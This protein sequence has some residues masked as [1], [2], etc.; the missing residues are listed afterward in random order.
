MKKRG[1]WLEA[2][3][4]FL[5][6][7]GS[8]K[9]IAQNSGDF[10]HGVQ[11]RIK[12][13][14]QAFEQE[15]YIIAFDRYYRALDKEKD[16]ILQ[17]EIWYRLG[18][19]QQKLNHA[20]EAYDY[21]IRVWKN[22]RRDGKF[23][24]EFVESLFSVG[25]YNDA[26]KVL[27]T[28]SFYGIKD[29]LL[30][31][32]KKSLA[33]ISQRTDT[34]FAITTQDIRYDTGINTAFSEYGF[35]L[36]NDQLVFSSTRP[37]K[38][39]NTMD[40]RTG[41]AYSKLY[42]AN[43][44]RESNSWVQPT[45][46]I[47]D[48]TSLAGNIGTFSY[49]SVRNIAYF[50]WSQVNKS[51]IYTL[52]RQTDGSWSDLQLFELNYKEGGTNFTGNVGHPCVSP[53]G[54]RLLFVVKDLDRNTGTDI[55]Y[56]ER[57]AQRKTSG[58][59]KK[60]VSSPL[61]QSQKQKKA[62]RS[63]IKKRKIHAEVIINKEWEIPVRYGSL[64]NT[65]QREVFPQWIDDFT[66]S[67]ASDGLVGFGGLDL[68]VATLDSSYTHIKEVINL[69]SPINS[70]FDDHSLLVDKRHEAMLFSSN[71]Y[72]GAGRTDNLYILTKTGLIINL[73]GTA[74]DSLTGEKISNYVVRASCRDMGKAD[75]VS[76]NEEGSYTFL[77]LPEGSYDIS[78]ESPAYLP[79]TKTI[80]FKSLKSFLLPVM[81][82]KELNFNLI[83]EEGTYMPIPDER[84][85][86]ADV[87]T[88]LT[89]EILALDST[90]AFSLISDI[91]FDTIT[92]DDFQG[93]YAS[94]ALP[95][96][97][98]GKQD[99]SKYI[100]EDMSPKQIVD[101]IAKNKKDISMV[102]SRFVS[103]Y[104]TRIN[105]PLRR[106]K[107]TVVP[108]GMKCEACEDKL[109]KREA[110][111]PFYV[112]SNDDKALITLTDNA[113]NVSYIDLAPNAAYS[114]E[115]TSMPTG[116]GAPSLPKSVQMS[117]IRK[118]VVTKDYILFECSPK[119][120]EINDETYVNNLYFDF[121]KNELVKDAHRELDRMIIIALKNPNILFEIEAHA[122]ERGS[123]EY[124]QELTDRRLQS[125]SNY[126]EKKGFDLERIIGK[127]YGKKQPLIANAKT[128]EEHRLNRRT[129]FTLL[130]PSGVNIK[131]GD[132]S[133][134]VKEAEPVLTDQIRF[135]L[136]LGA[137][138]YPL[139]NPLEYYENILNQY[140]EFEL[141][142]YMD[143][144]GLYKYNIGDYY[145]NIDQV[146]TLAKKVLDQEKECYIAAFYRGHR[147][148]VAEA[149]AILNHAK[150]QAK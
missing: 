123:E 61:Q 145:T 41:H 44:D 18:L 87:D 104:K 67:F 99:L 10:K 113:G 90:L 66:F 101:A 48:L 3:V 5:C 142:Y 135:K 93:E 58:K 141:T 107:L 130:L 132:L 76:A 149:L 144:D 40:P 47:G 11:K 121:D 72:S 73:F 70:S 31:I 34:L 36:V 29:S 147:I 137:F 9:A 115:V 125:T 2:L 69:P 122:D 74:Y 92:K 143:K 138:R 100:R 140:P 19:S 80:N 109:Q 28:M 1:L 129:T 60:R 56:V 51:G 15:Q 126:V 117:D 118:T 78:I 150:M 62:L 108:P 59:N 24:R 57:I 71:R 43:Y 95:V 16:T 94:F 127:S 139:D 33:K 49:D 112:R 23:M 14:D 17:A 83:R 27:D 81:L 82:S 38:G 20:K 21:F 26:S 63:N 111:K 134:P 116:V 110:N 52:Q 102:D 106:A 85:A 84:I 46:L 42:I 4:F 64:V 91:N 7:I 98:Q 54:N 119:L 114:I 45:R 25:M 12:L 6:L 30:N 96:G 32:R 39:E 128:E 37:L 79:Q 89:E 133:Y 88:T 120:S 65:R 146:R 97:E 136:Q 50:M 86:L 105:D 103:D 53:D 13:G 68:Y 124:N 77:S 22:G 35:A 131:K 8:G 148:T 75:T 55:W